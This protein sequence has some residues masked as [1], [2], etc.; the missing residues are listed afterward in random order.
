MK[1]I[2]WENG[3]YYTN[4]ESCKGQ[5][6]CEECNSFHSLTAQALT[7]RARNDFFGTISTLSYRS[8]AATEH[9]RK[10]FESIMKKKRP[11]SM[12]ATARWLTDCSMK[13]IRRMKENSVWWWNKVHFNIFVGC[14]CVYR[15]IRVFSHEFCELLNSPSSS[16]W[17]IQW[18]TKPANWNR[19]FVAREDSRIIIIIALVTYLDHLFI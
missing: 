3:N 11:L 18:H 14:V 10:E 7:K 12:M 13:W 19:F 5:Y 6:I 15:G 9:T 4:Q 2:E 17:P 16:L 8:L 1:G